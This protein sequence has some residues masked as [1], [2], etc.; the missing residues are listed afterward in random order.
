MRI[1]IT[2]DS[3]SDLPSALIEQYD[4]GLTRLCVVKD[5]VPLIDGIEIV[6]DDIF[7]CVD[8]GGGTCHTV[9]VNVADYDEEFSK[10]L[11]TH[12][13]LI[14]LSIS[15]SM[16][17][18][19]QNAVIAAE[20]FENVYV[21]DSESLSS[22]TGY[23][24]VEAAI[25]AQSGATAGDIVEHVKNIVSKVDISFIIDSLKYLRKG[26]RCSSLAS[27][28]ANVLKLKPCI[29]VKNGKMEVGKKYRGNFDKVIL[30]YISDKLRDRN[31]IDT[32][33]IFVT[34][35]CRTPQPVVNEVVALIK[36]LKKFDAVYE[37]T[38][39]CSISNHCGPV[40]L[41]VI[42]MRTN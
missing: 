40:C 19:H 8:S 4:I 16:S 1:K 34:F 21:V 3:T 5:G 26:G 36:S 11:A 37:T 31:D 35:P 29:E 28:G 41:G 27:L 39:G 14:H 9:A 25:L 7:D 22:G 15:S 12:D 42:F 23:L 32:S 20:K 30:Q 33:K 13:A 38:A 18:C 10:Y 24:A 6:P 17:S 2:M